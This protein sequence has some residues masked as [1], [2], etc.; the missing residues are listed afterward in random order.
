MGGWLFVGVGGVKEWCLVVGA[1]IRGVGGVLRLLGLG[2]GLRVN[3]W[4]VC[5]VLVFVGCSLL[6]SFLGLGLV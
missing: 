1:R 3:G 6:L 2:L 4:E 5:V